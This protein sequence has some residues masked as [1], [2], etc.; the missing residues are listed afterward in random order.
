MHPVDSNIMP[1]ESHGFSA[2]FIHRPVATLLL[3][4]G[5]FLIGI[6]AFIALPVA[7]LP[8]VDF[9]TINVSAR[10]PGADPETMAA[11]VASPLERRLGEIPGIDELTSSSGAGSTSI[12]AQFSL[13]RDID[14]A[15]HD[16]Q[17]AI[18]ATGADLPVDLPNPPTY[19]KANPADAPVLILAITS[20]TLT[21]GKLY[22]AADS[23]LSQ[24]ISQ[25]EGVAQVT[26]SG[27]A[28]P[29]VRV[30]VNPSQLAATG[31]SLDTVRQ[32]LAQTNVN[33]P[34]GI[35]DG[36]KNSYAIGMNDRLREASQFMGLQLNGNNGAVQHL[37]DVGL[38]FDGVEDDRQAAWFNE[39][40]AIIVIIQKQAD[41]NV[42]D[43]VNR[44]QAILPQL[45][46]WMPAGSKIE[47]LTDRTKT[48]RASVNDVELTLLISMLLVV[49]VVYFSLGRV[50]PTVAASVTVPLSLAGTF[51]IMW[52]LGYSLNNISLMA[53]IVSVGFVVDDAIVMIENIARHVERGERPLVAAVVGAKEITFTVISISISLIAVF[54]PLLFMGGIVGRLFREFA[55][56]LSVAVAFSAVISLS[57]TPTLYGHLMEYR[58]HRPRKKPGMVARAGET[59]FD[60]MQ[61]RYD[62]GLHWVMRHQGIMLI[63][64]LLTVVAT[65][66]LYTIVPKGFFPQQDTGM[67][68]ASTESRSDVSFTM[69]VERQKAAAK[70]ILSDPAVEGLGSSIGAGGFNASVNRGRMFVNLKPRSER[71]ASADEVITRLRPKLAKVEGVLTTMQAGQD[72]RVGG[73]GGG[74]QFQFSLRAESLEDL[75]SWTPKFLEALRG[76]EGISDVS[77]DQDAA[78]QQVNV[79]VDRDAASRL[80]VDMASVDAALQN[81]LSQRQI[82]TIYSQRNQYHVVLEVDPRFR[83]TP[84]ALEQVFLPNKN[85]EMV[86]LNSIAHFERGIA[87]LAV[88][89]QGQFPAATISFNLSDGASLADA[90]DRI[91]NVSNEIGMPPSI[92]LEFAGNAK[93]FAASLKDEP[94]LIMAALLAI[95]IVLGVLYE[96]TWHP[97]TILSTLPSAGIGAIL[98]LM[99]SGNQLTIIS[100][101]GI[102]LLM[103][104]VKKNGIMLVDFAIGAERAGKSPVDAMIEACDQRFRPILMTTMAAVLGAV[105][106]ILASGDG[107]ELRR[108]LGVAIVGGLIVSQ[109]LTLYTTPVVYLALERQQ[110]RL[111]RLRARLFGRARVTDIQPGVPA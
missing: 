80:G 54:I 42:I 58:A 87:P 76:K 57:V 95:Y 41:A 66:W 100:M 17:A 1:E 20:T 9:P 89:H 37:T 27:A 63:V 85:G 35:I 22:D 74:A 49:L 11:T 99:V 82:S 33:L 92:H 59:S 102:I 79:V 6:V 16:I 36:E 51:A 10:L 18:N 108:P 106:L 68:M 15:A 90:T 111:K 78:G 7:P 77:S 43:V 28:K 71:D 50:T 4:I 45:T 86:R 38:V 105:P 13:D 101:I 12:T 25:V 29:A 56:T 81:A 2:I 39:T 53:L 14:G 98:A 75:R 32:A 19:R 73:R 62:A 55:V 46:G 34:H 84:A 93:A 69:M 61:E 26:L 70:V 8:R 44:I 88:T 67:V 103:G 107:A 5:L 94:I 30:Q 40:P 104:I 3:S 21:R 60:W 47:V 64:M 96:N 83:E 110:Q 109:L 24:R 23:I 97:L 48:I 72:I 52:L 91:Q 31:I 65:I